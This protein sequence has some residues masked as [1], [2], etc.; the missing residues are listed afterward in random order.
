MSA[1]EKQVYIA[2]YFTNNGVQ[3]NPVMIG[4]TKNDALYNVAK[5]FLN[6]LWGK[7]AE[8]ENEEY[9][10]TIIFDNDD[11][12]ISTWY[13]KLAA[14]EIKHLV[15]IDNDTLIA[16]C[17]SRA[18]EKTDQ[19]DNIVAQRSTAI[20]VFVAAYGRR[21]LYDTL[22]ILGRSALYYDTDSVMFY[23]EAGKTPSEQFPLLKLGTNLGQ[24]SNVL[25]DDYGE[26]N[27]K[28]EGHVYI[29]EFFCGGPKNYLYQLAS[30]DPKNKHHGKKVFKV[31]GISL[32]R[33]DV[34]DKLDYD[35]AKVIIM[36]GDSIT[37][38]MSSLSKK[39]AYKIATQQVT[40]TYRCTR[41]KRRE[42]K[43]TKFMSDSV[44]WRA[45]YKTEYDTL[46]RKLAGKDDEPEYQRPKKQHKGDYARNYICLVHDDNGKTQFISTQSVINAVHMA[47]ERVP[48][49]T[50]TLKRSQTYTTKKQADSAFRTIINSRYIPIASFLIC[51]T[52]LEQDLWRMNHL[53][54]TCKATDY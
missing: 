37:V 45:R 23:C 46:I 52:Q 51:K 21:R 22:Q 39:Q 17:N 5:L 43:A 36:Q 49:Q 28:L 44:P 11:N 19:Q 54:G 3:L 35:R 50:W 31:K 16:T 2:N 24:L 32:N 27:S 6:S 34:Q 29:N 18:V 33:S 42:I 30:D 26:D 20:G 10:E 1:E 12:K 15:Y 53:G 41:T 4:D 9:D 48:A 40:K 13:A 8:K 38:E 7:W 47:Q 25:G 14:Q